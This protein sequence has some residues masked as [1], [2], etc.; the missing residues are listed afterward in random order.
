MNFFYYFSTLK[1]IIC[2][3]N[4]AIK[5]MGHHALC[6]VHLLKKNTLFSKCARLFAWLHYFYAQYRMLSVIL[7][8]HFK[9]TFIPHTHLRS[10]SCYRQELWTESRSRLTCHLGHW[11]CDKFSYLMV[12]TSVIS[13]ELFLY[14]M[15]VPHKP[16][17]HGQK[18]RPIRK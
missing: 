5:T 9:A 3:L 8:N 1:G 6:M 16:K 15:D 14:P 18:R 2:T 7:G 13:L 10:W 17:S 11:I 12:G 4:Y